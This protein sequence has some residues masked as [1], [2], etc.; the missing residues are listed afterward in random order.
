METIQIETHQHVNMEYPIAGVSDRV[1]AGIVDFCIIITWELFAMLTTVFLGPFS[2]VLIL[3]PIFLYDLIMELAF[4][5]QSLG[6][7]MMAIKVIRMDGVQP[8]V[9]SYLIRWM[10]RL[11]DIGISGGSVAV[12]TILINGKGQR[13]GDIAAGTTVIKLKSAQDLKYSV[14]TPVD[15]NRVVRFPQAVNLSETE[16]ETIREVMYLPADRNNRATKI[17]MTQTLK[18][19]LER[20]LGITSDLL[21]ELFLSELVKDYNSLKGKLD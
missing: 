15:E 9:S 20:K 17:K 12:V 2:L 7:K 3:L 14:F 5:G 1:L 11:I 8:S 6:K 10:F 18:T 16:I 19:N 13:L 21:P 4:D